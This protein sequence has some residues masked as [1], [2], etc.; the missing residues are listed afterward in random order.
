MGRNPA[1]PWDGRHFKLPGTERP[2][3]VSATE[4]RFLTNVACLLDSTTILEIGTGFG[5]SSTWLAWGL[6]LC[7]E[8]GAIHTVDDLTEGNLGERGLKIAREL[9]TRMGVEHL[10]KMVC[11]TSPQVLNELSYLGADLVFIDGEHRG[12]QPLLDYRAALAHLASDGCIVFHDVQEKYDVDA[13]VLAAESD[14]FTC[15]TLNTSC[16]PVV[17][18]R[19]AFQEAIISAALSLAKRRLLVGWDRYADSH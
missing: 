1:A 6:S 9:W 2:L 13:A 16:E 14:G 12:E 4:A 11:G 5:Y 7:T 10:V 15:I 8:P 19:H 17:A 18:V 3:S